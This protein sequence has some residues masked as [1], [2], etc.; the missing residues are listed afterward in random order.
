MHAG[1]SQPN[2]SLRLASE[3]WH[4]LVRL[5]SATAA[6]EQLVLARPL[7]AIRAWHSDRTSQREALQ[8]LQVCRLL[9]VLGGN[10]SG[11]T[12]LLRAALVAL[13]LGSDHPD[14]RL[15]WEHNGVDPDAFPRGPG[16][17]WIVALTTNDSIEYHRDAIVGLLPKW[18]PPH[19]QA[20]DGTAPWFGWNLAG[21]GE[22][23]VQVMVPGYDYPAV[24]VFKTDHEG[25]EAMQGSAC[26]CILHDEESRLHGSDTWDEADTRLWDQDGWH[27][28]SNTPIQ[29]RTWVYDRWVAN[30]PSD[31]ERERVT[32]IYAED[33]P[34]TS[35]ARIQALKSTNPTLAEAKLYGR[36][37]V[38]EGRIW[39]AFDRAVHVIEEFEMPPDAGLFGRSIDFGTRN[40][41]VHLWGVSLTRALVMPTGRVIPDGSIVVYREHYRAEWTLR[42]HVEEV[43]RINDALG[44]PEPQGIWAD[45]EDAQQM[46]AL[47]RDHDWPAL[48]ANKAVSSGLDK[49]TEYLLP[50]QVDGLP[51]FMWLG[52]AEIPFGR[53]RDTG[54]RTDPEPGTSR[55]SR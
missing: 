11:K 21:R 17:G 51:R 4:D 9:V 39:Q 49:V 54:G 14:A 8:L 16:R 26:R 15:F 42:Q 34:H 22:A 13:V 33:N 5:A 19:P 25:K 36:F 1:E 23:R 28:M 20:K 38:L 32:Y 6:L 46:L 53:S 44:E 48:K 3:C 41:F 2:S 12:F 10:R 27:L 37:V 43:E 29:G 52:P 45:P 7:A 24:I 31:P 47:R 35:K 50:A 30:G 18:G 55:I 40:P